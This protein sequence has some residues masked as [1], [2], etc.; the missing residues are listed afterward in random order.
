VATA[1]M[2]NFKV[3][4]T[5]TTIFLKSHVGSRKRGDTHAYMA[6]KNVGVDVAIV[7]KRLILL[8]FSVTTFFARW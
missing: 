6:R 2:S 4:I 1:T 7:V 3:L 8:S 5:V